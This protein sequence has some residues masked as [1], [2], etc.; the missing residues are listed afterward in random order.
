MKNKQSQNT[1]QMLK[2]RQEEVRGLVAMQL[3]G[4]ALKLLKG[5]FEEEVDRLCGKRFCHKSHKLSHR[6]G[7]EKG[8]VIIRGQR[9]SITRPRVRKGDREQSLGSYEALQRFDLLCEDVMKHMLYGVSTRNYESLQDKFTEGLG[10]KKSSVSKAF[11]AGCKKTLEE[12]NFRDLSDKNFI[13]LMIDGI[14]FAN[15]SLVCAL[16]ITKE[17]KKVILGLRESSTENSVVVTDLLQNLISRGLSSGQTRLFVLDGSK[18][19]RKGIKDVF[20][21][22]VLVQ[23]C[24]H[25]KERNIISYLPKE[26]HIEFRRRWTMIHKMVDYELAKKEHQS[27]LNWLEN[28]NYSAAE[29]LRESCLETLTTIRLKTPSSLRKTLSFTNPIESAFS[30]VRQHTGRVKNWKQNPR[31]VSLWASASLLE[32]EKNFRTIKGYKHIPHLIQEMDKINLEKQM[33]VA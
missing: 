23:R 3:Q 27:L 20:G 7:S 9:M 18:A 30:V 6:G 16:G 26:K 24:I 13:S 15:Q 28:I 14:E 31:Q 12:I 25:H 4:A 32:T 19:L 17:G 10:L 21:D 33:K 1:L 2:H 22:K 11:K 8:S 29:S 5:L